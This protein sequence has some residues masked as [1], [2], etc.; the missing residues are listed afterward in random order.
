MN[1]YVILALAIVATSGNAFG[2][3]C[4]RATLTVDILVMER[5]LLEET[6]QMMHDIWKIKRQFPGEM[7]SGLVKVAWEGEAIA[8]MP[9]ITARFLN[10][11]LLNCTTEIRSVNGRGLFDGLRVLVEDVES[12]DPL[13]VVELKSIAAEIVVSREGSRVTIKSDQP[14]RLENGSLAEIRL[15]HHIEL[16]IGG[17]VTSEHRL[18]RVRIIVDDWRKS[19]GF[20]H[21][22]SA[23]TLHLLLKRPSNEGDW[24]IVRGRKALAAKSPNDKEQLIKDALLSN[25][26]LCSL[27]LELCALLCEQQRYAECVSLLES[28]TWCRESSTIKEFVAQAIEEVKRKANK[29]KE[30]E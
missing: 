16:P 18:V 11:D 7:I 24:G 22:V 30:K 20:R 13:H 28:N 8:V 4:C 26:K 10:E 6:R 27:S 3:E 14:I 21:I 1:I 2:K 9:R 25:P 19:I 5:E 29:S 23:N 12:G 15:K 17:K